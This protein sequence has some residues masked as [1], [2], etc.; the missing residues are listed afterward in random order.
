MAFPRY[1]AGK[2]HGTLTDLASLSRDGRLWLE[3]PAPHGGLLISSAMLRIAFLSHHIQ[4]VDGQVGDAGTFITL[5][6]R[7]LKEK[8]DD[9]TFVLTRE[10]PHAFASDPRRCEDLRAGGIEL[11]EVHDE[12]VA[13]SGWPDI[14]PMRLSEQL[15]PILRNFDVVYFADCADLAIHTIRMKR[16]TN[17][18]TPVCVTVLHRPCNWPL[19]ADRR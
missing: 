2:Q 18:P 14:W 16:F 13:P 6:A 12:P 15:A 8:G 4:P 10:E 9:V 3:L 11:V 17:K 19:A 7:M 1:R 5:F